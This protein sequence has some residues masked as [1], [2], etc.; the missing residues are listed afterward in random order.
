MSYLI[1]SLLL[2]KT[3]N[4]I[5]KIA[6]TESLLYSL[7]NYQLNQKKQGKK[8]TQSFCFNQW[9]I[10]ESTQSQFSK[11]DNTQCLLSLMANYQ[12]NLK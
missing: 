9:S 8:I 6:N 5:G 12:L 2:K 1:T 11:I 10:T 4:Q 3:Q 7:I